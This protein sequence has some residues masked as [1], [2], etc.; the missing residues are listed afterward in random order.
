MDMI[1]SRNLSVH[2]YNRGTADLLAQ[3][4]SAIYLECLSAFET[5]MRGVAPDAE[6]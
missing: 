2:T 6:G 3:K 1:E 5:V 4:I